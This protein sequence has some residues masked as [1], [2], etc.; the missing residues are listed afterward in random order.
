[1]GDINQMQQQLAQNPQMMSE[2][3]NSPMMQT[4]MAWALYTS[5]IQL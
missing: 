3:I 5:R 1:M 2:M 4:Y